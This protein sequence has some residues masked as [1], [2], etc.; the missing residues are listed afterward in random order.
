MINVAVIC[1]NIN[2]L[3]ELVNYS[4]SSH[5]NTYL[6]SVFT[7][8]SEAYENLDFTKPDIIFI[9][10]KFMNTSTKKLLKD[11][12][13]KLV[14]ISKRNIHNITQFEIVKRLSELPNNLNF[15][16]IR[17]DIVNELEYLGFNFKYKGT[18][19]L[20]DAILQLCI[21]KDF[22]S[23]NLQ[24]Q[25]YPI[26]AKEYRKTPQNIK[27]SIINATEYMYRECDLRKV[28][29]YFAFSSDIRPSVK[30]IIFT[31]ANKIS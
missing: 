10:K 17:K 22:N 19:Y 1:D 15:G 31:I 6:S 29:K 12:K 7:S 24:G 25:I 26:I 4:A 13:D 27:N 5:L 16:N 20:I 18:L 23:S 3:A 30:Q 14:P 9:E 21:M 11:Y 28:K 2:F 8:I